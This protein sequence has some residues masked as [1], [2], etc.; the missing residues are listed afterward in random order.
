MIAQRLLL[1]TILVAPT[2][3][4][5]RT[6][7]GPRYFGGFRGG[8]LCLFDAKMSAVNRCVDVQQIDAELFQCKRIICLVLFVFGYYHLFVMNVG[9]SIL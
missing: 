6:D 5:I 7:C 3:R 4:D 1:F 9:A 2:I 8:Q